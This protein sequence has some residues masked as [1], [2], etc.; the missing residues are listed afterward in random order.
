L[1][2]AATLQHKSRHRKKN[3]DKE[4][5]LVMLDKSGD[6]KENWMKASTTD[7]CFQSEQAVSDGAKIFLGVQLRARLAGR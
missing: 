2:L 1:L 6:F 7:I 4:L 3:V 5:V